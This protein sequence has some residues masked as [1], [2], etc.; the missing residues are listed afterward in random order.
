MT[1]GN[2]AG[3]RG[4]VAPRMTRGKA[5]FSPEEAWLHECVIDIKKRHPEFGVKRVWLVLSADR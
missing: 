2:S 3:Q 4:K 5:S 1:R